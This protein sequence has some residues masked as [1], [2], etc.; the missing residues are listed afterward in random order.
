MEIALGIITGIICIVE[1]I[2]CFLEKEKLRKIIKPF[3]LVF[4]MLFL[5]SLKYFH[6]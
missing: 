2:F 3:C 4:L 5:L 6:E 1:L